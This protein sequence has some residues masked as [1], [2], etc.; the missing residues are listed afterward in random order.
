MRNLI[1]ARLLKRF[2]IKSNL[3]RYCVSKRVDVKVNNIESLSEEKNFSGIL[4]SKYKKNS[5]RDLRHCIK[6]ETLMEFGNALGEEEQK[7]KGN[8]I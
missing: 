6:S 7:V 2:S 4:I 5:C 3:R 8:L 1:I